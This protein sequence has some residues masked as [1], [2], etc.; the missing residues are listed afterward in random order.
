MLSLM[1]M[2]IMAAYMFA[3]EAKQQQGKKLTEQI[4]RSS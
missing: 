1:R 3:D 4:P 2:A